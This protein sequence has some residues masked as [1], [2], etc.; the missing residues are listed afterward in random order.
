[1]DNRSKT[2]AEVTK[3]ISSLKQKIEELKQ[4]K[5]AAKR[6][7]KTAH[8][9][10]EYFKAII[11]NSS[12]VIL[13]LDKLANITYASP[14]VKRIL[15]YR[16]DE[17][18]GTRTLDLIVHDDK[19]RAITDFSRT[20]LVKKGLIPNHFRMKH[21]NGTV[22]TFEGIGNNLLHNSVVAGFVMNIRDI[23]DRKLIEKELEKN[24][25]KYR[26]LSIIDGLTQLYNSRHFYVQLKIETER[27]NRYG[28]PLTLLFLD[29]DDFKA[30]N[31]AYGHIEGDHVLARLGQVL[32]RCLRHTDSAYRY[33]GE[34]FTIILPMATS[35]NATFTAER[36]RK[37][38]K[39]ETF[40]PAPDQSAHMT[41]SIGL[42]KYKKK[43]D[44]TVFVDRVDQL[45]YQA[46][47]NGKDCVY[48][49]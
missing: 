3:E 38:F 31:D 21:K 26:E 44:I 10:E 9:S 22:G 12:D 17:L 32:K 34:E 47:K 28:H 8:E 43:E 36:I 1:M 41:V 18:I 4:S 46:K 37:K 14:S 11:Q 16:P 45:M 13:V 20:L 25:K 35:K 33:G 5:S 39:K 40:S 49:E 2:T 24:E 27:S 48:C 19:P 29:L 23:T 15:G 7:S 30:F 42:A 6:V